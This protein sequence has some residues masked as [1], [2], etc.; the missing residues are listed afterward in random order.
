MGAPCSVASGEGAG[1][2]DRRLTPA[3]SSRKLHA[4]DFINRYFA[5][6][7][8]S[9]TLGE[10]AAGIRVS[11]KRAHELVHQLAEAQMIQHTAGQTR[12]IRLMDR[13]EEISEAEV[14]ARLSSMGWT[15]GDGA[16]IIPPPLAAALPLT[17]KGLPILPILDHV[18]G[19]SE[20]GM[21]TDGET[22]AADRREGPAAS[23][24]G[25]GRGA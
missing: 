6:W 15:I 10:L 3:M 24:D 4:L 22:E 9:P 12:G 14:L 1:E 11:R 7:G 23:S 5:K 25:A 2:I 20:L 13:S 17:E 16:R 8:Y 21:G 19:R 18:P